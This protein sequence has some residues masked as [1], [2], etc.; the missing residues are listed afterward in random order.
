MP[1]ASSCRCSG[2][3]KIEGP[4]G[5]GDAGRRRLAMRPREAGTRGA[6]EGVRTAWGGLVLAMRPSAAGLGRPRRAAL[7]ACDAADCGS[8]AGGGKAKPCFSSPRADFANALWRALPHQPGEAGGA[9]GSDRP[10][11]SLATPVRRMARR[12]ARGTGANRERGD[13]QTTRHGRRTHS[14]ASSKTR[15]KSDNCGAT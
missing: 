12:M 8:H 6:R 3:S 13:G 10:I 9:C 2:P 1:S 15:K 7:T 11:R 14:K 4:R 5:H